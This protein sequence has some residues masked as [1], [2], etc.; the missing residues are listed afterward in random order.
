M[1]QN[2]NIMDPQEMDEVV[3]LGC[4]GAGSAGYVEAQQKLTLI[5]E[6]YYDLQSENKLLKERVA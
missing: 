4:S 1:E 2:T 5:M 6:N 3:A